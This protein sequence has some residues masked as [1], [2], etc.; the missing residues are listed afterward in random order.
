M[1][2]G[3]LLVVFLLAISSVMAA[4]S[5]NK[6]TVTSA[7]ELKVVNSNEALLTLEADTPW[8]WENKIGSKDKTAVVKGGE[9]FFQFGKGV[10]RDGSTAKFYGLQPN[11]EYQWN[12]LFTLRNK[13]AE[14]IKV[15]I[16]ATGDYAQY[17]T[18]GEASNPRANKAPVWGTQGQ[19]L[20]F[21][22][23][24][25][26]SGSGMQNIR[27]IAVKFNIP[28]GHAVSQ[29]ALLGSIIVESEAVA[30]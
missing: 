1:K 28:S 14:T 30:D 5:Y 2:K 22:K 11:S 25:K 24:T 15:T 18:F 16:K 3:L 26:E 7:S 12:D 17:I 13:S 21:D 29:A 10:D 23:V 6:A 9:L 27:T 4:M 8:S 20:V 19:A